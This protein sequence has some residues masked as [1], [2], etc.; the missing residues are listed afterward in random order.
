MNRTALYVRENPLLP[1]F[2]E[3]TGEGE[4]SSPGRAAD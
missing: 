2:V 4:A 3:A 1:C